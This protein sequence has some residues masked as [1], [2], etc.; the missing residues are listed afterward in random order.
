[1]CLCECACVSACICPVS[2][3]GVLVKH[4]LC[5]TQCV[6]MYD[7]TVYAPC[8]GRIL[9][10]TGANPSFPSFTLAVGEYVQRSLS[11]PA[12]PIMWAAALSAT[13][14][15]KGGYLCFGWTFVRH[16]GNY[17]TLPK[18][19]GGVKQAM[20]HAPLRDINTT[21]QTYSIRWAMKVISPISSCSSTS[22][23]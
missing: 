16:W 10:F 12:N 17:C 7:E 18:R 3:L 2:P 21:G 15:T 20:Q 8:T 19:G 5:T 9:L 1:M 11:V 23:Y 13:S 22:M 6:A 4:L 14:H